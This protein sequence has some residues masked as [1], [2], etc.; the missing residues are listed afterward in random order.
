[1]SVVTDF[2]FFMSD[3]LLGNDLVGIWFMLKRSL[4]SV[5]GQVGGVDSK[6]YSSNSVILQ[7]Y[8]FV[9]DCLAQNR[10]KY[11]R[12]SDHLLSFTWYYALAPRFTRLL[13]FISD[14]LEWLVVGFE[15]Y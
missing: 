13:D 8:R 2:C 1:M 10:S 6:I 11:F 7:I 14:F 15:S 5:P 9:E 4:D 12:P 3:E